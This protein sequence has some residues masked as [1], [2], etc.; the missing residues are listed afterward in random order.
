MINIIM[1]IF[2]IAELKFILNKNSLYIYI[3]IYIYYGKLISANKDNKLNN[4]F[5]PNLSVK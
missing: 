3:Y 4:D 5:L 1:C 2:I